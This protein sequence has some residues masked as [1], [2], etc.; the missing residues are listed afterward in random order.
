MHRLETFPTNEL[1]CQ[2]RQTFSGRTGIST[3]THMLFDL[4]VFQGISESAEDVAL[5]NY[6]IRLLEIIGGGRI[7]GNNMEEFIKRL[8]KQPLEKEKRGEDQ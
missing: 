1:I 8:I 2:Y 6:G 4:G 3:L 7:D 5:K